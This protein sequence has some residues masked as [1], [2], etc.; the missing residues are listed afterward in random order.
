MSEDDKRLRAFTQQLH[1]EVQERVLSSE[2]GEG[3]AYAECAFAELDGSLLRFDPYQVPP[4][5]IKQLVN[6][7]RHRCCR[8]RR[9]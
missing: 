4:G 2:S 6:S 1:A 8:P 5:P 7:H 9:V 3:P